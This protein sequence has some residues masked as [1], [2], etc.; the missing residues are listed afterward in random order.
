[1]VCLLHLGGASSLPAQ[2]HAAPFIRWEPTAIAPESTTSR[3]RAQGKTEG[4]GDY[5]YEGLAFGG[6]VFGALGVWVGSRV[7]GA[8]ALEPG[9]PCPSTDTENA[10]ALG[11]AGAAIGGG[12]GYLVGRFS[13]Q[14]AS[15]DQTGV[16]TPGPD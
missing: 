4:L 15:P 14:E 9:I 1:V 13:P 5:R 10:I 8:C 7:S 12:L 16:S 2:Q 6:V 11:L 3:R